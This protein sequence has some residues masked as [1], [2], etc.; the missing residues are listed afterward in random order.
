[1]DRFSR[2]EDDIANARK[3][4]NVAARQLNNKTESFPSAIVASI[5]RIEK[6]KMF[7][8]SADERN[9]TQANK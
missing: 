5:F 2:I 8:I 6:E 7:G 1:M 3:Y 9:G 4:Y